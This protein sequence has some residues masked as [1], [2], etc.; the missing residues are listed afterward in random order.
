M[1]KGWKQKVDIDIR[2]IIDEAER[3]G[4]MAILCTSIAKDGM[5]EGPDY[6]GMDQV[7]KMTSLL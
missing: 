1:V 4:V 5:L 6:E 7:L 2:A 3:V